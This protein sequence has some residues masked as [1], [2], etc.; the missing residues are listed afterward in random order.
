M[1]KLSLLVAALLAAVAAGIVAATPAQA[2]PTRVLTAGGADVT[3]G[4]MGAVLA[5]Y[6]TDPD[7]VNGDAVAN[8]PSIPPP[9]ETSSFP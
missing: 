4:V 8:I 2:V 7:N 9:W 1:R 6:A 3:D 5:R